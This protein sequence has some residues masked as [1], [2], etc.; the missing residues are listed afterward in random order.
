VYSLAVMWGPFGTFSGVPIALAILVFAARVSRDLI[1]CRA[2]KRSCTV[3]AT[4]W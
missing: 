1:G 4:V 3:T 2:M